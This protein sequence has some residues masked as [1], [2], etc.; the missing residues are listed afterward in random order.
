MKQESPVHID[1]VARRVAG[2]YQIERVGPNVRMIIDRAIKFGVSQG[3]FAD[4]DEFLWSDDKV[5]A[6]VPGL[7]DEPRPI[8]EVSLEE[9]RAA[10]EVIV[11]QE[12]GISRDSLLKTTARTFGY[13]RAGAKVEARISQAIDQLFTSGRF[14]LYREQITLASPSKLN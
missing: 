3:L 12:M 6:R 11:E 1:S 4:K 2:R 10:L 7:G 9:I 13:D 5:F 14:I 8:E